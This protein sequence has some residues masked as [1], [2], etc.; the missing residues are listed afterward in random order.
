M[1]EQ[2]WFRARATAS[3][4]TALAYSM[5]TD[6]QPS[7]DV[8]Q[9]AD[10]HQAVNG[11]FEPPGVTEPAERRV[12]RDGNAYTAIEFE[13]HYGVRWQTFWD[14]ARTQEAAAI[15]VAQARLDSATVVEV[16]QWEAARGRPRSLHN[17]ARNALNQINQN[18][19]YDSRNLD[20]VFD[21]MA[22]VA[23]HVRADEIIGPGITHAMA[24]F[25][26]GSRDCNRGG[27]PRL[28]FFFYRIDGT[29]CRVHP[30]KRARDDAQLI[31]E[32][33]HH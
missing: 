26:D 4:V 14:A 19:N 10:I 7:R 30:G 31:I 18:P 24:H 28:D 17:I 2:T 21:W 27:A 23:A 29:V 6:P 12:A 3:V 5:S 9:L 1:L 32:Q 13:Q 16:R 22:Y 15:E 25:V 8:A 33:W 11:P 20:E